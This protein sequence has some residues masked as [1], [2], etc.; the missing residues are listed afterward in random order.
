[1]VDRCGINYQTSKTVSPN[2]STE[3]G[4]NASIRFLFYFIYYES[5]K[6]KLKLKTKY[7]WFLYPPRRTSNSNRLVNGTNHFDIMVQFKLTF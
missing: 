5:T 2:L 3:D 7:M 4:T 6:R 1:M